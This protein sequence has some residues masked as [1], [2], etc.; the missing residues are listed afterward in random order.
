MDFADY[1][2]DVGLGPSPQQG[3]ASRVDIPLVAVDRCKTVIN[4]EGALGAT[5]RPNLIVLSCC[6]RA[7]IFWL[8]SHPVG[9][10]FLF[11]CH[12]HFG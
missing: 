9:E 1:A 11:I 2:L 6:L 8:T 4:F 5:Y 10:L 3:I 12:D 7:H